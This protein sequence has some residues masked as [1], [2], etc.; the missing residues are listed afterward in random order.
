MTKL[1]TNL[2]LRARASTPASTSI[3]TGAHGD[4][5]SPVEDLGAVRSAA[6]RARH[7]DDQR[8]EQRA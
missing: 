6:A 5:V 2:N 8:D 4:V 1:F 3:E 7:D